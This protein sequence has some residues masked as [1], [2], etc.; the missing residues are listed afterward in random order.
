VCRCAVTLAAMASSCVLLSCMQ[1]RLTLRTGVS[2]TQAATA[3][4]YGSAA[5]RICRRCGTVWLSVA[6]SSAAMMTCAECFFAAAAA[7]AK[8]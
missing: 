8:R 1:R 4:V 2:V 3:A 5:C 6:A 7:S